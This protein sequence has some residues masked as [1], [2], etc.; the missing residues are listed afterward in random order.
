MQNP[1]THCCCWVAG[2]LCGFVPA[3]ADFSRVHP[4][5]LDWLGTSWLSMPSPQKAHFS[6]TSYYRLF[7]AFS[8][9]KG[10]S[11]STWDLWGLGLGGTSSLGC[12]S[13]GQSTVTRLAQ[14][15]KERGKIPPIDEVS[16]KTTWSMV[17]TQK[18]TEN[19]RHLCNQSTINI[20]EYCRSFTLHVFP[21][22]YISLTY[23]VYSW[24]H[25]SS[26]CV[27]FRKSGEKCHWILKWHIKYSTYPSKTNDHL[28]PP[29]V[30]G[31]S[32]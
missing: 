19:W 30:F 3:L 29:K 4:C 12:H 27:A 17:Y 1:T 13:I 5:S 31:I 6:S 20:L 28:I 10:A 11:R 26:L 32:S 24:R 16:C 21:Q 25:L 2:W 9:G 22:K 15:Q 23:L 14:I 7:Q 8:H 18:V